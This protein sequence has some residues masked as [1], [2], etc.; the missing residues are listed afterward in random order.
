VTGSC[1]LLYV[2]TGGLT[3]PNTPAGLRQEQ[4][5]YIS[6][7]ARVGQVTITNAGTTGFTVKDFSIEVYDQGA[8]VGDSQPQQAGQFLAP[9][10]TFTGNVDLTVSHDIPQMS[11][12]DFQSATCDMLNWDWS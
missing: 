9:G 3:F 12:A 6:P 11:D 1:T 7:P 4:A 10:E 2:G 5:T 8:V